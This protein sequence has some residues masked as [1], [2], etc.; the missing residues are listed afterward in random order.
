MA[1]ALSKQ[2]QR[3]LEETAKAAESHFF[4]ACWGELGTAGGFLLEFEA[5][6]DA[7]RRPVVN[8]NAVQGLTE[9]L[10]KHVGR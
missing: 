1:E 10:P 6:P 2:T 8:L 4:T 7:Q 3:W 5:T 9:L